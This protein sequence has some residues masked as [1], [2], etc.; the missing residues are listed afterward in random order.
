MVFVC[1]CI[2]IIYIYIRM[3]ISLEQAKFESETGEKLL[4]EF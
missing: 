3:F 2:I 1:M 4:M